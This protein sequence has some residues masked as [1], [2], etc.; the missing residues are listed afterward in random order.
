MDTTEELPCL[1]SIAP[2]RRSW[3]SQTPTMP[4]ALDINQP[5]TLH[6]G[7]GGVSVKYP[8]CTGSNVSDRHS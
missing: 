5:Y 4:K 8:S 2:F 6:P 7:L 3:Q 1:A